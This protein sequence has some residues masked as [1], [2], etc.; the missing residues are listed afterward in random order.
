MKNSTIIIYTIVFT[1]IFYSILNNPDITT[2][3][4]ISTL[5]SFAIYGYVRK[6]INLTHIASI[7]TI[8]YT[9]EFC[10]FHFIIPVLYESKPSEEAFFYTAFGAQLLIS[11]LSLICFLLRVQI[12]RAISKSD[13]ILTTAFDGVL[14]WVYIYFSTICT[15]AILY[16]FSKFNL[17]INLLNFIYDHYEKFIYA[18]MSVILGILLSMLICHEKDLKNKLKI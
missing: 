6:N 13:E 17:E 9:I 12:S 7:I 2:I 11:V 18:G 3:I 8:I 1:A 15:L 14:V 4:Y 5:G 16:S 10:I